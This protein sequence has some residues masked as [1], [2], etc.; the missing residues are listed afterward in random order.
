MEEGDFKGIS[1][2]DRL[3][4]G[5]RYLCFGVIHVREARLH[6]GDGDCLVGSS[7]D[8]DLEVVTIPADD[9]EG[10]NVG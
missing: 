7:W 1:V 6:S 10:S 3:V 9:S 2:D 5:W 8:C 4:V